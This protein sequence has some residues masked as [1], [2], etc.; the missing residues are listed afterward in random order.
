MS[1]SV[2]ECV[3]VGVWAVVMSVT[4]RMRTWYS[5]IY[6]LAARAECKG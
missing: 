2:S 5:F 1:V 4:L 6:E 3:W